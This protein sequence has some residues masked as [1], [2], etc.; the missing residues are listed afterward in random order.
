MKKYSSAILL[1]FSF[2][3]LALPLVG[4]AQADVYN[5][6]V[7]IGEVTEV[8]DLTEYIAEIYNFLIGS[9][10]IVA[11]TMIMW[12]GI[13][14]IFAAGAP[15]KISKAKKTVVE[16]IIGLVIALT[17]FS[18][19]NLINPK[20]VELPAPEIHPIS[21]VPGDSEE[22]A[23]CGEDA[24]LVDN[25]CTG[26]IAVDTSNITYSAAKVNP[27][28]LS[29]ARD[30]FNLWMEDYVANMGI[31]LQVNSMSRSSDYQACLRE[32]LPTVAS[33]PCKSNHERGLAVDFNVAGLTQEQYNYLI[34]SSTSC[35]GSRPTNAF[36]WKVQRYNT[37]ISGSSLD[38]QWHFDYID[39]G[40][41]YSTAAF[42]EACPAT[43]CTSC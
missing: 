8:Q 36:G 7:A 6:E 19:L 37:N 39:S 27:K 32:E 31:K 4:F 11:T 38:E 34:C 2:V 24:Q 16:A 5:L 18:L 43:S 25:N 40:K 22:T 1:F 41:S 33:S 15:D 12:G 3:M 42:C 23:I 28:L 14:W 20:L 30:S 10:G 13:Q 21:Y 35:S 9:V 29:E 26:L 17:S